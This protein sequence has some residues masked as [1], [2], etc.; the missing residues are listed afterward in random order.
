MGQ[1]ALIRFWHA[2]E[3]TTAVEYAVLVS[4][5][6]LVCIGGIN[7]LAQS[8]ARPVQST[9]QQIESFGGSGVKVNKSRNAVPRPQA[10]RPRSKADRP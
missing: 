6:L 3:G 2:H 5:L 1:R 10:V 9:S 8:V 4:L 7:T